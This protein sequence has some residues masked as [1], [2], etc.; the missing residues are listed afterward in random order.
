[1]Q[2]LEKNTLKSALNEKPGFHIWCRLLRPHTLTASFVPVFIGT[3]LA[4]LD[5]SFHLLLFLAMLLASM[6][7]QSATNMFNEYYD[8]KRGLDNENSVGIGGTIVR[9][10]VAPKTV[11]R[12]ALSFFGTSILL[13][14][15]ICIQSNWW[16]ALIGSFCMLC[17]YFYT[18]GPYP[19]AYTPLGELVSGFFMGPVIILI[20]YFI[21]TGAITTQTVLVSIPVGIFI[22]MIMLANNIRDLQ[23]DKQNGR[24]TIAILVGHDRAVTLLWSCFIISFAITFLYILL[25][26]LP[27]WSLITLLAVKKAHTAYQGFKGKSK[28]IEMVPAMIAAAQTNTFYGLLLGLSLLL[29]VL[30]DV[31]L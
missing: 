31:S 4:V 13:G 1:M 2:T 24:K 26:M 18:G 10:G 14:V 7:I 25:G 5:Q 28:S 8:F 30:I 16:I 29:Q 27:V 17:G 11:L 22:G 21:Q 9:D 19:I 6:L 3:M 23:G 15:Y 12:L 20:S